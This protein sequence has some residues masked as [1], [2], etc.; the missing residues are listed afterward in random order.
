ME[1]CKFSHGWKERE[2]H[3]NEYKTKRCTFGTECQKKECAFFHS[4]AD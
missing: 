2:Y 1:L 4:S 3:P